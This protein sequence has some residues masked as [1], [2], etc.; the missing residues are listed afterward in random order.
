[1]TANIVLLCA[2]SGPLGL[3][4]QDMSTLA[5]VLTCSTGFIMLFKIS[6]PFNGLRGALF[7]VLLAAFIG[8][9]VFLGE[10]FA[11][12]TLTLPMLIALAPML[13][14]SIVMML[15][16]LHLV[17]HVIANRQSP[18]RQLGKRKGR[19]RYKP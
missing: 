5:V 3:S 11:L 4:S 6:T 14:F 13:L 16:L 19:R 1:M 18:L 9:L 17:D 2:L 15:A 7:G 8:A 12:T 10:F